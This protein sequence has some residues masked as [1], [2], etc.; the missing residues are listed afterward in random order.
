M[1]NKNT[2]F[3]QNFH[4]VWSRIR[5][6]PIVW[7]TITTTG[8]GTI[9][10]GVGFLVPFF[11]A[12]WFGVTSETDAFFFAYGL[13]LFFSSVF[14]PIAENMIVPYIA[15]IR[16]KGE[17]VGRFVGRILCIS[18]M[19]LTTLV[20]VTLLIIKPVLSVITHFDG[21]SLNLVYWL[22]VETAPLIVLLIW[23]SV[24]AGSLN[25]YK[26]FAFPAISPAFRA[27]F[28]IGIIFTLKDALG[29][30]A[31]ALGYVAGELVRFAILFMIIKIQKLFKLSLALNLTHKI[32][33][34]LKVS[35]YRMVALGAAVFNPIIDKTMATWLGEGNVSVLYYAN[36]IYVI[37]VS[38]LSAGLFPVVLSHW[39]SSYYNSK[40]KQLL[41]EKANK[42]FW[43]TFLI[44]FAVTG[45]FVLL[46][47]PLVYLALG[48]GE[49]N[50]VHLSKVQ[51]VFIYY[52][53]GLAPYI[54]GSMFTRA[55][56]ILKRTKF[57]MIL[58]FLNCFLNVVLNY[59]FMQ[60]A[61][62]AGIALSTS[63]TVLIIAGLL[64]IA[65]R[66]KT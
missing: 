38:F 47:K 32:R 62:V 17:D 30:H 52:I 15:E 22:F 37:P 21:Q 12:A 5:T 55:H 43:V 4:F 13:I 23:T 63:V 7:D 51:R 35:F 50:P 14:A 36:I 56:L 54:A 1:K 29:V 3:H 49:F 58:A 44:S 25:A 39:S 34:F 26:N 45:I 64:F 2:A 27:I 48:R 60:F 41:F 53:L 57:L 16:E 11:I 66:P 8:W 59:I 24:L 9:G 19:G 31:I 40:D 65:T 33:E 6:Q 20:G 46:S 18:G 42:T 10:K 28:N 61:G